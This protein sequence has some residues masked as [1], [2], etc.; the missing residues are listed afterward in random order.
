MARAVKFVKSAA[1]FNVS[2][3]TTL[4][5]GDKFINIRTAGE[6]TTLSEQTLRRWLT[7]GRLR[8]FK[9]GGRTLLLLSD[10]LANVIEI[11]K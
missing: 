3:G 8:R 7:L 2:D 1:G 6:L 11:K 4:Q 10:V 5:A 9:S